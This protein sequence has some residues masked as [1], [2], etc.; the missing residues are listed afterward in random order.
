MRKTILLLLTG[1]LFVM[2]VLAQF[3][4]NFSD[5]DFT[6]NPAWEGGTTDWVVNAS[7]QLQSNNTVANSSYYLSTPSTLATVAQWEFLVQLNFNTSSANYMDVFLIA[8]A[9]DLTQTATSGYFVRMGGTDDEIS[10]FRKDGAT[11]VKIIDGADG[12]LNQSASTIKIKVTRNAANQ[13][14]LNR[15]INAAAPATEGV[16]TDATYNSSASFGVFVKQST[17]SFF[18]KHFIDDIIV[19]NYVPDVTAPDVISYTVINAN[20]LDLLFN[21]PLEEISAE[22]IA[23]Y[24]VSNGVGFPATAV[25]D[26]ANN[27]LVHLNFSTALPARTNLTITINGVKDLSDNATNNLVVPFVYSVPL[28]FDVLI[29]EIMADPTPLNGLPDAEWIELRNRSAFEVNLQNW[30]IGK[31]SGLSGSMPSYILKPD[32]FVIVCTGSAVAALSAFGPVLSVTSF[33]SL[34]NTGD[35]LYL[36]DASG[37]TIHTVNYTDAWYQNELKKDGGWTLEMTDT[38]NPCAGA[39][40]WKASTDPSGGTPGRKNSNDASNPDDISPKLLR[41]YAPDSV[42]I[43]L[44]F[45]EPLNAVSAALTT[46]YTVSDG[47]GNPITAIAISPLFD[48]VSLELATALQRNRIYTVTV[49]TLSDCVNNGIGTSNTARVGLYEH[50]DSLDMV[51]NEVLFNPSPASNDYVEIYNRSNKILNLRQAYLANLNTSGVISSI[52]Q[53]SAEDYLL[54]PGDFM[55]ATDNAD[56]VKATYITQNPDAFIQI[57]MPSFNDDEGNVILLNEQGNIV[58]QLAYKDDWHFKLISNEE[59]VSLERI[60]YNAPTQQEQNWHSAASSAGYGTPTYKNSQFRV[61]ASVQGEI[62]TEPEIVSPDN[63][64]RDDFASI[65]YSFPEPGYVANITVFDAVGRTVRVL[66][67]NA[68]CGIKGSYRWDGLG[69]KNQQL[70]SGI[71]IVY[72]EV[73]NLSGKTKKF[74]NSIVLARKK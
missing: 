22:T 30:K 59:G 26:A 20:T 62:K 17:A 47:I 38:Q 51:V 9:A 35:L 67:R 23:N 53:L 68:L 73:F 44:V 37:N 39:S 25:L 34:S 69:D 8:S 5:G 43:T 60:D 56:L 10:L 61:D 72:T 57:T 19:S 28:A 66:Q 64:G 1:L 2:P 54:F 13:W 12:S 14:Q 52:T 32:S 29:D 41:A 65:L 40:N 50:T 58:D 71:Y 24:S 36:Q 3:S 33:P 6:A 21:E 74:K 55:V 27:Q 16:V 7:Q 70:P 48:R 45:D 15:T 18:Q 11:L 31:P 4:E 42:H 49:N 63:D 46:G